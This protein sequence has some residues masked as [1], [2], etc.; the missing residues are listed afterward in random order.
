M[1][2]EKLFHIMKM[3][4]DRTAAISSLGV[5]ATTIIPNSVKSM[6]LSII[7]IT[8][9]RNFVTVSS[10]PAIGYTVAEKMNTWIKI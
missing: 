4:K 6:K 9:Q 10:N 7:Y 8:N 1:K 3:K 2:P 5:R